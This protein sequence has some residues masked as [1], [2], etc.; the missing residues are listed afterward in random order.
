ML[1]GTRILF[2]REANDY[3]YK[4]NF[5]REAAIRRG[6]QE[7]IVPT[8][9]DQATFVDKAGED[10]LEKMYTF[11]DKGDRDICLV[12]EITAICQQLY[13]ESWAKE[14]PKPVKVFYVARCYRYDRPQA[15][16]YREFTQ[17]GMEMLGGNIAENYEFIKSLAKELVNGEFKDS[18]KRGLTYYTGDGFEIECENLGAQ[19]QVV[20]GG[21]YE[22]GCG[23]ALG[24]ERLILS[25][26]Q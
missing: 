1:K 15:G 25:E 24:V 20:G 19:K 11:K 7:L 12:P 3:M 6:F 23:F 22:E 14:L 26:Q 18:V 5:L 21:M 16:R 10:I 13:N 2:G 17:F 8:I 4:V 9:W